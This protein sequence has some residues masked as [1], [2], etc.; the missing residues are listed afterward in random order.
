MNK[1]QSSY[2]KSFKNIDENL[3]ASEVENVFITMSPRFIL[4]AIGM[5]SVAALAIYI[6]NNSTYSGATIGVLAFFALGAQKL[7]PMMQQI[8]GTF[9]QIRSNSPALLEITNFLEDNN[10]CGKNC[11]FKG[12]LT[13]SSDLIFKDVSFFYKTSPDTMVIKNVNLKVNKG[14]RIGVIGKSGGGKSTLLD[15]FMGLI[16]PKSGHLIADGIKL[17]EDTLDAWRGNIAH[18]PQNIYIFDA[19][20]EENIAINFQKEEINLDKVKRLLIQLDL[21]NLMGVGG[22]NLGE[23][24]ANL[25]GGQRQRIG[26]ARALYNGASII[27]FDE[28]TSA[29]DDEAEDSVVKALNELSGEYTL[30]IV[31]HRLSSL[32]GCNR[33]LR[34]TDGMVEEINPSLLYKN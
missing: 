15:I 7:I 33:L 24:G 2:I 13:F 23:N 16:S 22:R 19:T 4:E 11:A 25:S 28:P 27:V 34:V 20:I 30:L 12:R 17:T 18:V 32:A 5:V 21:S 3:R 8:Y 29:L 26:I 9:C 6:L 10:E 31:A 14:D 1:M